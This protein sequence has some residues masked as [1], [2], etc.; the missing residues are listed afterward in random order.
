MTSEPVFSRCRACR[1]IRSVSRA[2]AKCTSP[3][4]RDPA[5][6]A[7]AS[8]IQQAQFESKVALPVIERE[9]LSGAAR[10]RAVLR[11]A[12]ARSESGRTRAHGCG[13]VGDDLVERGDLVYQ[14]AR[15]RVARAEQAAL[16][17]AVAHARLA[18]ATSGRDGGDEAPIGVV[19]AMLQRGARVVA[20]RRERVA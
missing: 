1:V 20:E 11:S 19:Y 6:V 17:V 10:D 8:Q 2:K 18:N 4:A 7:R 15:Q 9:V 3:F 5:T 14:A 16:S 12:S 13:H